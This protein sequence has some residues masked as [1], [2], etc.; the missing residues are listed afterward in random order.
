[1]SAISGLM[2]RVEQRQFLPRLSI[3]AAELDRL[4]N[5]RDEPGFSSAWMAAYQRIESAKSKNAVSQEFDLVRQLR[6]AV[7]LQVFERW[8]SPD[9][10]GYI[11]DDFG[12]VADA[13]L[14]QFD[15]LWLNALLHEYLERRLP[16]G[17]LVDFPKS[18]SEQLDASD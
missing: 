16:T 6:E 4:L 8:G 2:Q 14:L 11:S 17:R 10:A 5:Q 12:L 3:N 15:D 1:M 13:L 9:L 7:Y 18:L